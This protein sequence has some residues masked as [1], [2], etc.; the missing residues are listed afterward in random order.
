MPAV[1]RGPNERLI[2]TRGSRHAL[3]T[4]ALVLDL[5][6]MEANIASMAEHAHVHG[7]ALRPVAK[8]HKS[9]EI[10][11]RQ[12][13]AGGVGVCCAT[14]AESEVMADAGV[15]GVML[16]TSVVTAPKLERLAAL[17]ARA[18]DLIVV[19]D[20]S[21]NLAQLAQAGRRSGRSLQLL[22]D[23]EVG[24]GR[25]GIAD[26]QRAVELAR[27]AADTDGL[28][29]AGLHGYVGKHQNTV[30]YDVRRMRSRELLQPLVR[31]AST[32]WHLHLPPRSLP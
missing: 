14:L 16:F 17:N 22:V 24:G 19:A 3:G 18:D 20:D 25:T 7:Y 9:V 27:L 8:I 13:A 21:S 10:A 6:A 32:R 28:E 29:Y 11:R 4:P 15:P 23:I 30:D 12:V 26:E 5:D 2:A 31:P 1:T